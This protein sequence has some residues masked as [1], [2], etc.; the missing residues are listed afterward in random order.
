MYERFMQIA[1]GRTAIIVTHRLASARLADRILVL[2][3]GRIVEDGT[4]E[5]LLARRGLYHRM[6]AAQAA[7]VRTKLTIARGLGASLK[8]PLESKSMPHA[9]I[10][11]KQAAVKGGGGVGGGGVIACG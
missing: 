2:E 1:A 4:H 7:L 11:S 5:Q 3:G 8:D 6:F 9:S 10:H